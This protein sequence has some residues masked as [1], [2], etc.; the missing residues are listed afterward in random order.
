VPIISTPLYRK[1]SDFRCL[2]RLACLLTWPRSFSCMHKTHDLVI[3]TTSYP[4]NMDSPDL[5]STANIPPQFLK[6]AFLAGH[7][8]CKALSTDPRVSYKLYI[9]P[10][11]INANPSDPKQTLPILPLVIIIHG[12]RRTSETLN[13]LISWS[14]THP[15]AIL[16]PLFPAGLDGPNDIDSYKVLSSK[17]LR[18]DLA[19]L[20][21]LE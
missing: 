3:P 7:V 12:T 4:A 13:G 19:L 17:T 5:I 18:S 10:E 21:I 15:C 16:A 8:P 14:H 6:A 20:S 1:R 9:P 11:H 2:E